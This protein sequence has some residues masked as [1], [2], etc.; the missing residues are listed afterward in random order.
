MT[1]TI[2]DKA[3]SSIQI[4]DHVRW[5]TPVFVKYG[6]VTKTPGGRSMVFRFTDDPSDRVLPDA[7]W[8]FVEGK[9]S[10]NDEEH[11]VVIASPASVEGWTRLE[12]SHLISESTWKS[13]DEVAEYLNWDTKKVRRYIRK[14]TIVAYKRDD[15]WRVNGERLKAQAAKSGWV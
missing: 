1:D 6:V 11:L 4:G 14:G 13:V 3:W 2:I 15:R 5:S 7:R 10:P 12:P 8:Y 9:R